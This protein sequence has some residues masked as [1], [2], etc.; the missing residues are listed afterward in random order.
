MF[1]EQKL[2]EVSKSADEV[3]DQKMQLFVR[4]ETD[5]VESTP[6]TFCPKLI[7][8]FINN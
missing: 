6:K 7:I 4:V 3:T 2:L 1:Y 8:I 5:Q